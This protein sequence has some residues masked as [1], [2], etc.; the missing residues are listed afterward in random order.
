[1]HWHIARENEY[2]FHKCCRRTW[3]LCGTVETPDNWK[4]HPKRHSPSQISSITGC[5]VGA[6]T[7][8]CRIKWAHL[9]D[10]SMLH[11]LNHV[12]ICSCQKMGVVYLLG[13]VSRSTVNTSFTITSQ[14]KHMTIRQRASSIDTHRK[15]SGVCR[16]VNHLRRR[17]IWLLR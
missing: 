11:H 17:F 4:G 13:S 7:D 12:H 10:L 9:V 6:F 8:L 5:D 15:L 2:E 1:M 14:N 16:M 3:K